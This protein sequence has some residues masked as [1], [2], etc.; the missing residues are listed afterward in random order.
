MSLLESL[1]ASGVDPAVLLKR[2]EMERDKR[3]SENRL[4]AYKPY[5]KQMEFHAAGATHRERLLIAANQVGKTISG[6][7]EAAMHLTGRYPDN[8]TGKRFDRPIRMWA[9]GLTGEATRDN[10]QSKLIGPPEREEHWGTGYIPKAYLKGPNGK[11]WS[12]AM[13]TANLLDSCSVLHASGT[14]STVWFKTY[15]QGRE[16]WQGPTLDVVW[17]DEEPPSDIYSEG[18]TRTNAVP[19]AITYLTFT[20]LLGMSDVVR[21]FLMPEK[22]NPARHVTTMTLEDA[23]HFTPE[24]RKAIYDSY[25]PYEREARTRGIPTM[26]SGRIFPIAEELVKEDAIPLPK[27][28]A[29]IA[30]LDFGWDHPTAVAWIAWDRD[31]DCMHVYDCYRVSEQTP[32]IH[33]A[34]IKARSTKIPVAWPHD[35]LQH[36]KGSGEQ[37]AKQYRDQGVPLLPERA[38]FADDRGNG[39][40]AGVLEMLERMQTGRLKIAAHLNDV[41]DEF[42]L[43]HRDEGKIV[44][45]HDD[46]LCAIRYAMMCLRFAKA[47]EL[48]SDRYRPN[49]GGSSSAMAA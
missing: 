37:L 47:D 18:L 26:G 41:W 19:D 25:Q 3:L 39:V 44:K 46:L 34:A 2:L 36:D 15:A 6:G 21:L 17:F 16:K 48:R 27:H 28:W 8:W 42:R 49:G 23:E 30:G 10:V 11:P 43:Y 33:A 29:K 5:A 24:Q 32:L 13:G 1:A 45:E 22:P 9:A 20:P 4:A 31:A 40:E 7:A 12:R 38:Q 35:G 14:Y